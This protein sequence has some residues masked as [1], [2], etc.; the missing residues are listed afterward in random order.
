MILTAEKKRWDKKGISHLGGAEFL[1][2]LAA[3]LVG[4][5]ETLEEAP[6]SSGGQN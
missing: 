3:H 6:S 1:T 5:A 2:K 4:E